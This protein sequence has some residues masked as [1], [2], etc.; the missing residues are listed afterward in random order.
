MMV[1]VVVVVV[2]IEKG[3]GSVVDGALVDQLVSVCHS[4]PPPTDHA[5]SHS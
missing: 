3:R 1:V 5:V 4:L 2:L